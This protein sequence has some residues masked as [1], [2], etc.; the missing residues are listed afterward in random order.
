MTP[1]NLPKESTPG[2]PTPGI[3]T[4][5][6]GAQCHSP[7]GSSRFLLPI[8][9]K[10]PNNRARSLVYAY[11]CLRG[12]VKITAQVSDI[13]DQQRKCSRKYPQAI[14]TFYKQ[15]F[16]NKRLRDAGVLT[17]RTE[18]DQWCY[19]YGA[20]AD[21]VH[22]VSFIRDTVILRLVLSLNL[23]KILTSFVPYLSLISTP[24]IDSEALH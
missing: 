18:T 23:I 12:C 7:P 19:N 15:G 8:P 1:A 13:I 11:L 5:L 16:L 3:S 20:G 14:Q 10:Q 17:L 21:S 6:S 2:T 4:A 22:A 24:I 9:T